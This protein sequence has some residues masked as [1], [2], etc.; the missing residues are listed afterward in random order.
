MWQVVDKL[1]DHAASWDTCVDAAVRPSPFLRSWWLEAIREPGARFVMA[2]E[3]SRLV[4]GLPIVIDRFSG[5]RRCRLLGGALGAHDLDLV[6]VPGHPRPRAGGLIDSIR[7]VADLVDLGGLPDASLV[8]SLLPPRASLAEIGTS[9]AARLSGTFEEYLERRSSSDRREI[10]RLERRWLERGAVYRCTTDGDVE[11]ATA[12][13]QRL[14]ELRWG[15]DPHRSQFAVAASAGVARGEAAYHELLVGERVVAS[16]FSF[17]LGDRSVHYRMARE[18]GPD[19]SGIGSVLRAMAIRRACEMGKR[20][21]D[22]GPGVIETKSSWC[23]EER[24]VLVA[25]WATRGR[26]EVALH[27]SR[28]ARPVVRAGRRVVAPLR[29]GT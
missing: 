7:G 5:I 9:A 15:R 25:R 8:S 17:E 26:G 2:L 19:T 18:M 22:L 4:G 6:L 13:L 3:D 24:P 12:E 14:Y 28:I 27:A 21:L 29:R 23:D 16:L 11:R 10:R 20:E 1:G